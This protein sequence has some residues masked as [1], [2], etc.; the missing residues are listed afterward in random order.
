MLK[1]IPNQLLLFPHLAARWPRAA[2]KELNFESYPTHL[3]FVVVQHNQP[4]PIPEVTGHLWQGSPLQ[5][6]RHR[7][8]IASTPVCGKTPGLRHRDFDTRFPVIASVFNWSNV[9]ISCDLTPRRSIQQTAEA[10]SSLS[11]RHF[12]V[13]TNL[14][15]LHSLKPTSITTHRC[16][17]NGNR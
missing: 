1:L 14:V 3:P 2:G 8:M 17:C 16:L 10:L 11:N 12:T 15:L 6:F 4:L 7:T 5:H 13:L 9:R